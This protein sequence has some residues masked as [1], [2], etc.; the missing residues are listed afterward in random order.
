MKRLQDQGASSF[1][2]DLRDNFGGLVQVYA[3]KWMFMRYV[4]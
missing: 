3:F 2:L 4:P 1:V